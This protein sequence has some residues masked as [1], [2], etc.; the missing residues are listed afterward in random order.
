MICAITG[1][2]LAGA[3]GASPRELLERM[4]HSSTRAALICQHRASERDKLIADAMGKLATAK[5]RQRRT[6]S[7]TQRARKGNP[8]S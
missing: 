6:P 5:L 2:T 8:A 4:G 1:N 3:A 7:G